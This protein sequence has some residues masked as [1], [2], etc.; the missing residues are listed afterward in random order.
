MFRRKGCLL[1]KLWFLCR[2]AQRGCP[3]PDYVDVGVS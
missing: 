1:E 3:G 2:L